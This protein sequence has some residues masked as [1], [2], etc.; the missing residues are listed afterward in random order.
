MNISGT[1]FT[2][3]AQ[4]KFGSAWK[5]QMA[6]LLSLS[7]QRVYQLSKS[8]EI[9]VKYNALIS[10][11]AG[12]RAP[13]SAEVI[14]TEQKNADDDL[15]DQQILD[16]VNAKFDVMNRMVNGMLN[17]K[18]RS[19]IVYG[20]PGIGKTYD[21]E[22]ALKKAHKENHLYYHIIKGTC[23]A[24]GLYQAL[25]HAREG[26]VIVLDDCDSIFNDEQAF[27]ILK[28]ALDST[29]TRTISWRKQATWIYDARQQQDYVI[30]TDNKV[31][32][33]F[34]FEGGVIFITNINMADKALEDRKSSPHFQ[35]LISRSIYL[36]LTLSSQRA[37]TLRIRDIFTNSMCKDE[38]LTKEEGEEILQFVFENQPRFRELSLRALKQVC[39]LYKLGDDWKSL[40]E[41]T[42]MK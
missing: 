23:S 8:A 4:L 14:S 7:E 25:Y 16:R 5:K 38:Q 36:D 42:M 41:H 6:D 35:A 12:N 29:N 3:I 11:I 34:E 20:P 15:S 37:R 30:N 26:G 17:Q 10:Q 22:R 39:S 13:I 28:S 33:E 24:P 19:M 21:I 31:P 18:I 1:Q 9:P 40:V 2:E 27:N 32:N